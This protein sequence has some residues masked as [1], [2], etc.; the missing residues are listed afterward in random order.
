MG[1][2]FSLSICHCCNDALQ[3]VVSSL[4]PMIKSDLALNFVQ[5]GLLTLCYQMTASIFQPIFGLYLDRKPNPHFIT[6]AACFTFIGLL[7]LAFAD[8]FYMIIGAVMTVGLGSSIVHPEASRLTSLA[9]AGKRGLAQSIFQVGGN[10]GSSIGP[11]LAAFF[12]APYGRENTA[13]VAMFAFIG[14]GVSFIISRWYK[15]LLAENK[16]SKQKQNSG[17]V[18]EPQRPFSKRRTFFYISV[19]IVL[20]L[21]KFVYMAGMSSY[22]TF[23]TMERFGLDIQQ[24]QYAL[25]VFVFATAL[26]TLG[27]GPLGDKIGRKNVIWFSIL[28]A[29]PCAIAMPYMGLVGSLLCIFGAGLILSSA[30]PAIVIMA[31]ELL[32]RRIGMISGLFFGLAFGIAG[33]AAALWG[34]YAQHYGVESIFTHSAYLLPL[35][36]VAICLPKT[37]KR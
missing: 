28:G 33:I 34:V 2:L 37:T 7:F 36:L 19:L 11:L 24:A 25:F 6:L 3:A 15:R 23:Y 10:L 14:I 22:F 32:P 12:V 18:A 20:I 4:Y 16:A 35:G 26:G 13:L 1:I 29:S 31:Q 8:S 5:I 30:F 27:G 21:S 17:F 9:S